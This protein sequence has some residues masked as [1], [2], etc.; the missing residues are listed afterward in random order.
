MQPSTPQNLGA[1]VMA[2]APSQNSKVDTEWAYRQEVGVISECLVHEAPQAG[3]HLHL[4]LVQQEI[5][6]DPGSP[7]PTSGTLHTNSACLV[8]AQ[9]A[10]GRIA[11]PCPL[12]GA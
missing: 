8:L 1:S 3:S 6:L 2:W 5:A 9:A 11:R 7:I 10:L 4:G 12:P